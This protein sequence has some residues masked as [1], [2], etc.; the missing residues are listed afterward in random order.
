M[1]CLKSNL[2]PTRK[3]WK[4]RFKAALMRQH[5]E[6]ETKKCMTTHPYQRELDQSYTKYTPVR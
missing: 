4:P 6:Q 5:P 2:L 1:T 3:E